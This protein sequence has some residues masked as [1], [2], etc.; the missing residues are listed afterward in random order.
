MKNV[1]V[2]LTALLVTS[3][4][5]AS[6]IAAQPKKSMR[7]D[8]ERM[9]DHE[10][11]VDELNLTD[12][13]KDKIEALRLQHKKGMV[14]LKAELEK[15][16]IELDEIRNKDNFTRNEIVA[17]VENINKVKNE[18]ALKIANHRMDIYEQLTDDQQKIWNEKKHHFGMEHKKRLFHK[19]FHDE[20]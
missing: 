8:R 1:F 2:I 13:Q 20:W 11:L 19:R 17:S 5:L 18:I 12:A 6:D 16:E 9:M 7:M 10:R 15:R 4:L 3:F 14:D